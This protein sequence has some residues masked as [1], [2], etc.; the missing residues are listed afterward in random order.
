MRG[1]VRSSTWA[2]LVAGSLAALF[3]L[4]ACADA[5]APETSRAGSTA[6][7]DAA[8]TA[9]DASQPGTTV[10]PGGGIGSPDATFDLQT[11]S[12]RCD[13]ANATRFGVVPTNL[14][15]H[16]PSDV[17]VI[18]GTCFASFELADSTGGYA[19]E[20]SV[21][22]TG[23]NVDF[24]NY[25]PWQAANAWLVDAGMETVFANTK[26]GAARQSLYRKGL[27]TSGGND[28]YHYELR[29]VAQETEDGYVVVQYLLNELN[30]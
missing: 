11:S 12:P 3:A 25:P 2:P 15:P 14:P 19:L 6:T 10:V 7:P 4:A 5:S 1:T 16:W 24:D 23:A 30:V 17:P 22:L 9:V 8:A 20:V 13:P 21:A 27:V 28:F 29:L 18:P 26:A